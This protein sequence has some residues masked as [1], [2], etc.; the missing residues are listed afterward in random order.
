[1]SNL[2]NSYDFSSGRSSGHS[3]IIGRVKK[4]VLGANYTDTEVNLDYENERDLGK[5]FFEPLY[6]NKSG[7][8]GDGSFS[9]PAYPMFSFL[10]QYPL[11]GEIVLI[12][13]GA[14]AD[15]N[16]N[17]QNQDLWYISAFSVWNSV[18][19]NVFPSL[20]EY[21]NYVQSVASPQTSTTE[22]PTMPPVPQGFTFEE[23][24]AGIKS[25]RPFEGDTIFQGRFGQSIRFGSTVPQ[26]KNTNFWSSGKISKSGDPI[27][28]ILNS[29]RKFTT[30]EQ[31]SPVTVED[32]NRD[33]TSI[34][35]TSTQTINITALNAFPRRSYATNAS[36]DP[37]IQQVIKVEL[38]P[39]TNDFKSAQEQDNNV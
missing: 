6:S 27:T 26:L 32:I 13:P 15:L 10:R 36:F 37:Q 35:M 17:I 8:T 29:P 14:T 28:I 23:K 31:Q 1:M 4:V 5:I 7:L 34:Y 38:P 19:Q 12:F 22:T 18:H 33:G 16:D 2:F 21:R 30:I 9:K 20:E 25:L 3:Y 11:I 24:D 39:V